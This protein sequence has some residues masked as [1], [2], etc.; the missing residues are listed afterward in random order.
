MFKQRFDD[1]LAAGQT[2]YMPCLG[3]K[4]FVPS[5][6]GP[7]RAGTEPD[8]NVNLVITSLLHEMWEHKQLKPTFRQNVKII[9]GVMLYD[10]RGAED[11]Q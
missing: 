3:W 7:L 4:E 2:F 5:Y 6:F 1:R 10:Q 8:K 9:S 11:A